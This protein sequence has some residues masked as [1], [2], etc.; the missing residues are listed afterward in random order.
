MIL[1]DEK[2]SHDDDRRVIA[3]NRK[4]KLPERRYLQTEKMGNYQVVL[5][6]CL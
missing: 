3:E 2:P 4:V 5:Q 6:K 1:T